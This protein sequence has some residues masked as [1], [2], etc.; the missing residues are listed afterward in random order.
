MR[1]VFLFK[2]IGAVA[3]DENITEKE[4]YYKYAT[5]I[6]RPTMPQSSIRPRV[7]DKLKEINYKNDLISIDYILKTGR[8]KNKVYTQFYKG[9]KYNLFAWLSDVLEEKDGKLYKKTLQGTYWDATA[10]TKNLTKEGNVEFKSGKKP[11]DLIKK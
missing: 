10:G 5:R 4:V 8:N 11:L 7:M 9:D 6:V 2:S 1:D 3:K